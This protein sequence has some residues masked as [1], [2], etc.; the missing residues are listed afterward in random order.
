MEVVRLLGELAADM[1]I[2]DNDGATPLHIAS[3]NGHAEV[4]RVLGALGAN[5]N[6]SDKNGMTPVYIASR[7]GRGE[8]P[9]AERSC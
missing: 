4:S 6:I 8:R 2:A 1:N 3:Q 9:Q 7:K 5:V